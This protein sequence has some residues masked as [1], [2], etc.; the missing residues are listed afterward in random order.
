MDAYDARFVYPAR[1][2]APTGQSQRSICG[3]PATPS[4]SRAGRSNGYPAR[5]RLLYALKMASIGR[6]IFLDPRRRGMS[7]RIGRGQEPILDDQTGGVLS[8]MDAAGSERAA[9]FGSARIR[10]EPEWPHLKTYD[11]PQPLQSADNVPV[12]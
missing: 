2:T 3:R 7:D 4:A 5:L 11:D 8:V 6:L 9:L 10:T 1:Q 12:A